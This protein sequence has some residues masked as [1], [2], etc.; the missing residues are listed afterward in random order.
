MA[1]NKMTTCSNCGKPIAASAKT[2][3]NCGAK[4]K[5]PIYKRP[6]FIVVVVLI[7]LAGIGGAL[8]GGNN[9][10]SQTSAQAPSQDQG[11]VSQD[12]QTAP[13]APAKQD[14]PAPAEQPKEYSAHSAKDLQDD[15][16]NN[17]LKAAEKYKDQ[18]V[19][20]SG[21]LSN[22]DSSGQYFNISS[23]KDDYSFILITCY[24]TNDEQKNVLKELNTGAA[25]KVKGKVK[26]VGEVLGYSIDVDEVSAA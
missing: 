16:K 17:A 21:V 11:A 23:S 13:A 15:L 24:L 18:Y 10:S 8:G 25:V 4:N 1:K 19:E 9:G 5:K 2:C 14:A 26:D 20:V 22:I 12:Q 6:W 7:V 3:P